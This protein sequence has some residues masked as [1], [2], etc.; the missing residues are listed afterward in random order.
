[1]KEL[2]TENY[3]TLTKETE[4]NSKKWKDISCYIGKMA[5]QLTGNYRFNMIHIKLPMTFFKEPR[6]KKPKIFMDPQKIQNCQSNPEEKEQSW[7]YILPRLKTILQSYS[8]QNQMILAQKD[9]WI[10]GTGQRAQK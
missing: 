4:D 5:I 8:N 2:Y 7:R 3:K 10:N 9:I 6:T 1:M